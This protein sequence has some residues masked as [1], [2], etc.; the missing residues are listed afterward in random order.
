MNN[1]QLLTHLLETRQIDLKPSPFLDKLPAPLS[2]DFDFARIE[3][4]MLSLAI[5]DAR[6]GIQSNWRSQKTLVGLKRVQR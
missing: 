3:G 2:K 4:M 5:G 1:R 6:P